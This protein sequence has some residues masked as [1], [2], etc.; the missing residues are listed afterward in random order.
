[1][2]IVALTGSIGMGK[3]S[4]ALMFKALG[5]PVWDADEVVHKLYSPGGAAIS[6]LK[7]LF[8]DV[9]DE[10]GVNRV[11]LANTLSKHPDRLK[12][13]ES[14]VHPLVGEDRAQFLDQARQNGVPMVLLDIPLLFETGQ[15]QQMDAIVVVTCPPDVQKARVLARQSMSH[16]T[17]N[18][19]VA[20]Q[21]PDSEKVA[22][23][24]FV[25]D[26]SVGLEEARK[27]VGKVYQALVQS[28]QTNSEPDHA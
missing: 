13:L 26:T 2:K 28:P 12:K 21:M 15:D 10:N 22:R 23:A 4:T 5:V 6:P 25:I 8:P 16:Q 9:I 18:F 19:I 3:S 14:I 11:L 27:Q 20:R 7:A 24:D 1:M 17:F